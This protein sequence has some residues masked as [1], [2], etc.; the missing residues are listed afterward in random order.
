MNRGRKILLRFPLRC[1]RLCTFHWYRHS[2]SVDTNLLQLMKVATR[3]KTRMV[4][5]RSNTAIVGSNSARGMDV[6]PRF[7]VLCSSP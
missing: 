3:A 4:L 2:F 1:L 7:S 6:C 5:D